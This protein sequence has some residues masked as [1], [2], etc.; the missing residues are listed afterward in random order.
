MKLFFSDGLNGKTIIFLIF[1]K[2][3]SYTYIVITILFPQ[4]KRTKMWH[5]SKKFRFYYK[6]CEASETVQ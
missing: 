5:E 1:L 2:F 6:D 4:N 3:K